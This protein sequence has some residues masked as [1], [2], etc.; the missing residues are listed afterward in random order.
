[1]DY[2]ERKNI[3]TRYLYNRGVDG[4]VAISQAIAVILLDAGVK[5]EKIRVIH[6]GIDCERFLRFATGA[7]A[8]QERPII[9]T[10]AVL[11]E[12]KGHRF[13]LEAAALLKSKGYR[14]KILLGGDGAMRK[15]LEAI[16][17]KLELSD[18][19]RFSGFVADTAGFLSEIDIFVLPSLSEG[20]GV[21]ALEGMAARKAVVASKVGGL[22]ESVVDGVTGYLVPPAN[23]PALADALVKL[24]DDPLLARAMGENGAER[25]RQHFTME[26]MAGGNEAFY[27]EMLENPS[28]EN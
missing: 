7:R 19:V 13:L 24:V 18:E 6:S 12:R 17:A 16:T 8:C 25:V 28:F 20:L 22:A 11:E 14:F 27:H 1:M 2:A 9:G 26:Q 4:V 21:A 3:Y 15:E 10:L 5:K 23:A